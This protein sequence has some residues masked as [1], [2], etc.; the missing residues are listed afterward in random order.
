MPLSPDLWGAYNPPLIWVHLEEPRTSED[1]SR[2]L[3]IRIKEAGKR[4]VS[5]STSISRYSPEDSVFRAIAETL[6]SMA[7]MQRA[8]TADQLKS[9]LLQHVER[10]VEPF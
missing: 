6:K 7:V 8:V 4:S 10:W 2:A 3:V 9:V 5:A 1:D